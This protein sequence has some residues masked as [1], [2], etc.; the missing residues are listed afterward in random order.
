PGTAPTDTQVTESVLRWLD[1]LGLDPAVV[2]GTLVVSPACG[3]AGASYDWTRRVLPLLRA[4]AA[5]LSG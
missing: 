1:M 2:G 4:T 5:H 3:L